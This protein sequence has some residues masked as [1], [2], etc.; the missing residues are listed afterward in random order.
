M[1][2]SRLLKILALTLAVVNVAMAAQTPAQ[3]E[4]DIGNKVYCLCGCVTSLNTCPHPNCEVKDEMLKIIRA[5]LSE[6]KAEPAILQDLVNRYGEKVLAAPP[7]H[8]FNLTA[9]ILPGVGLLIGLFLAIAIVRRWRRPA[10]QLA[11][12][13]GSPPVDE[14]VLSAVEEEMKKYID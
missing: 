7:A 9:W 6:G 14:N 3:I 11:A 12:P 13:A 4:N 5:D 1:S 2:A 10:S 8:G